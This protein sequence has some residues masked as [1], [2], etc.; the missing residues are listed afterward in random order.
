MHRKFRKSLNTATGQSEFIIV[1]I[2]DIR[3]FSTFS[4][5]HESPDTAQYIKRVYMKLIDNYFSKASFYKST[6]DGLLIT[7]PYTEDTLKK[8]ANN[9]IESCMKCHLEFS[10]IC[11]NDPM[12]NFKVPD[13]I[14]IGIARGTACCIKSG[15]LILDYSGHILNLASRLMNLARPS[16]I[17]I[18]GAFSMNLFNIE[19]QKQFQKRGVY[20]RSIAE[21]SPR[22]I[23][24]QNEFVNISSEYLQPLSFEN[25]ITN[26]E[27]RTIRAWEKFEPFYLYDLN[28][29]L[30]RPDA[31]K[32]TVLHPK[33]HGKKIDADVQV[34]QT[35]R[36]VEYRCEAGKPQ[37][38]IDINKLTEYL[39]SLQLSPST[40]IVIRYEYIPA[41]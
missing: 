27:I 30:K 32:V 14:G 19:I 21:E 31:F 24:I 12:I 8:V 15:N 18:D 2:L 41:V 38:I 17:V 9:T 4:K 23:F 34:Y 35:I 5:S 6:G 26:E 16:G 39:K 20:L 40:H 11:D 36:Y 7:I 13:K 29:R 22:D 28:S 37:L 1:V 10:N 3:G 25:W 33:L